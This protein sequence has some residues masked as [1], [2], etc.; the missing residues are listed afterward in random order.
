MRKSDR[1]LAEKLLFDSL[2]TS[3]R[4]RVLLFSAILG[5]LLMVPA[6]QVSAAV[7][8]VVT[9]P[10][11]TFIPPVIVFPDDKAT[12]PSVVFN[13][14]ELSKTSQIQN[15]LEQINPSLEAVRYL[16]EGI[17]KMTGQ[18][19]PVIRSADKSKGIVFTT[20]KQAPPDIQNDPEIQAALRNTGE[21]SY[22]ANEA[23]FIRTEPH[24]I[25][26]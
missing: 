12:D 26:I 13:Y 3:S 17:F 21:N 9:S 6:A 20:L 5:L 4:S 19:L 25:L 24:R 7:P 15:R 14:D 18:K 22:N 16:R 1:L 11:K 23:F 2:R 10:E 8:F